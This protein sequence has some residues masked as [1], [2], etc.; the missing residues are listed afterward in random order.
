[1]I[2]LILL[3]LIYAGFSGYSFAQ[4]TKHRRIAKLIRKWRTELGE[5]KLSAESAS[6]KIGVI[7]ELTEMKV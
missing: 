6:V 5:G 1:M 7:D 4:I 3:S 2:F